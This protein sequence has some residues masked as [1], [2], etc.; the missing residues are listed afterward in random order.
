MLP[1]AGQEFR[2]VPAAAPAPGWQVFR[3][4]EAR[5]LAACGDFDARGWLRCGSGFELQRESLIFTSG[6]FDLPA[7]AGDD[8]TA[9]TVTGRCSST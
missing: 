4:G 9:A 6:Q 2:V 1:V 7:S 3:Q 8:L 5:P